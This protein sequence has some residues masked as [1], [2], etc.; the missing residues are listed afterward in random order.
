[1]K[2]TLNPHYVLKNDDGCV[3]LLTK[4]TLA[5]N[6]DV[7][8][9]NVNSAIH[10][11]HAKILS[12]VNGGEYEETIDNASK[13]LNIDREKIKKFIDA[14]IENPNQIGPV[15]K[16]AI[17]G[18][19]RNTIIKSDYHRDPAYK[20]DDFEYDHVDV[21][22]RRH[23]TPSTL[24]L[25]INNICSTNC[26]YCYADKR[27]PT[28]AQIP[29]NRL[30]ELI[31]EAR[32]IGVVDFDLIGGEVFLYK[33]WKEL[34]K[35]FIDNGY[36]PYLSTK[37]PLKEDDVKYLAEIGLTHLQV[38]LDS[39][40]PSHLTKIL[41]VKPDY[42]IE[43][44]KSF[45]YLEKYNIPVIVHSILSRYG[46]TVEDI[47]SVYDFLSRYS[48][49][50]YWLTEVA[51]PSIYAK[52]EFSEFKVHKESLKKL[53]KILDEIVGKASF[54]V[55]NGINKELEEEPKDISFDQKMDEFMSRGLCSGNFSHMYILPTGDV[56]ICE[57]LY[58]N[59]HFLIGDVKKQS[60]LEIW[61]SEKALS[62]YNLKQ[63]DIPKDSAC[64]DCEF[65]S[66]CRDVRQMCYRD[67]VKAY[68][69]D[70]WYYPDVSCPK[71]PKPFYDNKI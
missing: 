58:W 32:Q 55:I 50:R 42:I 7:I 41:R 34:V 30:K 22:L 65:F 39:M 52:K 17:I 45:C 3:L 1:M 54:R 48:N 70:K 2:I 69:E 63:C 38:S 59:P 4:K 5:D 51:G 60:L 49:I 15:Y 25:M 28:T 26:V 36:E 21:A 29:L 37:H 68:G 67:T 12:F 11:F 71:A 46:E 9:D 13:N 44:E 16:K 57:E 33:E 19:P 43:L 14:L 27:K 10:P 18:F 62:V 23:K 24:T 40:V 56:T 20:T 66:D 61:T 53:S 47:M 31:A 35:C 64:A 6:D 8:D